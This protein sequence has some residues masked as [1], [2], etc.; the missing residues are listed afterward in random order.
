M[1][2][3]L[4]ILKYLFFILYSPLVVLEFK[5]WAEISIGNDRGT[6]T[7]L[8][9][10]HLLLKL[11][12]TLDQWRVDPK[13]QPVHPIHCRP[14]GYLAPERQAS[15]K[16]KAEYVAWQENFFSCF[17]VSFGEQFANNTDSLETMIGDLFLFFYIL[18]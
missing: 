12:M 11:K 10:S 15:W 18:L 1:I 6:T 16:K 2:R 8:L 17:T 14:Y 5:T 9:Q 7:L 4:N 3:I 13:R